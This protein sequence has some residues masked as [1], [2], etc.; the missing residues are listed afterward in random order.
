MKLLLLLIIIIIITDMK[1]QTELLKANDTT[2][3]LHQRQT[4]VT[5]VFVDSKSSLCLRYFHHHESIIHPLPHSYSLLSLSLV[6]FIN[7]RTSDRSEKHRVSPKRARWV[8]SVERFPTSSL[9]EPNCC[10][11]L[12]SL[13]YKLP[14]L[15]PH[16]FLL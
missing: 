7:S 5:E 6:S 4:L 9:W 14:R 1:I 15:L 10:L 3:M 13:R 16:L 8:W 12:K 2:E 11:L